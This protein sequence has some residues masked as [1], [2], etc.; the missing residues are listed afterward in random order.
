MIPSCSNYSMEAVRRHG[1][2]L[3]ILMTAD[4]LIHEWDEELRADLIQIDGRT[5]CADPVENNDFWW[6]RGME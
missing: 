4:R 2:M 3:G 6:A 5:L 1:A